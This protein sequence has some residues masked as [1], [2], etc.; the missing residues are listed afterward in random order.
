MK[1]I[2]RA[3]SPLQKTAFAKK[4][5]V[6][7][8]VCLLLTLLFLLSATG[9][10]TAAVGLRGLPL[11]FETKKITDVAY[12]DV[13]VGSTYYFGNY[14]Q[15]NR[16]F[17]G[18]E[19]IEWRVLEKK[20]GAVLLLSRYVLDSGRFNRSSGGSAW[21]NSEIRTWLNSSFLEV[22]FTKDE[23][24]MI[25][26]V[27][28]TAEPNATYS[29]DPGRDTED[30][31]F[32]LS[33]AEVRYYLGSSTDRSCKPSEAASKKDLLMD[34]DCC[35]WWLRTPGKT[36]KSAIA[37][38]PDGMVRDYGYDIY[39]TRYGIRPAI[40]VTLDDAEAAQKASESE[41]LSLPKALSADVAVGENVLFGKYEQDARLFNGKEDIEW[42]V[43]AKDDS[44]VLLISKYGLDC[45]RFHPYSKN[46]ITWE[47]CDLRAWLNSTFYHTAFSEEEQKQIVPSVVTPEKN[48]TTN[49]DPGAETTDN[50]FVL[51]AVE[52]SYYLPTDIVRRCRPTAYAAANGAEQFNGFCWWWTRTPGSSS[53]QVVCVNDDGAVGRGAYAGYDMF[54]P[55]YA[56]RP[57]IRVAIGE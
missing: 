11:L 42:I 53:R 29:T 39:Y 30:Q 4:R 23:Q 55:R 25:P 36:E 10:S 8:A 27:T 22:A 2:H 20:D 14:E 15:D 47:K 5:P 56:V 24:A 19:R 31:A 17:N 48:P 44:S 7:A 43:I 49:V 50:V 34:N 13:R 37:V 41:N 6:F 35:Y 33:S 18:A 57:S 51:S 12:D 1:Q 45:Q 28:V 16:L 52:A 32:L 9:C 54:Y 26:T 21:E 40:W 3:S 46:G 38:A